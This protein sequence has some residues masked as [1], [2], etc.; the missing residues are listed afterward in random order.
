CQP[1]FVFFQITEFEDV[2][3]F[4]ISPQL[5]SFTF[6]QK[7]FQTP[8][9]TDAQVMITLW[10]NIKALLQ[11]IAIQNRFAAGAFF[12]QPFRNTG[13]CLVVIVAFDDGR[14]DLVDPTHVI[15]FLLKLALLHPTITSSSLA[16]LPIILS[17][18]VS[19]AAY[20]LLP[21]MYCYWHPSPAACRGSDLPAQAE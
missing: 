2:G 21:I 8:A 14:N 1:I 15:A 10:T 18:V 9:S 5:F 13:T 17:L 19:L 12:P 4:N 16:A 6:I 20:W 7:N 11:V 3:R